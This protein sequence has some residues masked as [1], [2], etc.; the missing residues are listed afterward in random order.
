MPTER[1]NQESQETLERSE[2]CGACRFY[3]PN[4]KIGSDFGTCHRHPPTPAG[5]TASFFP[6]VKRG[7]WCGEFQPDIIDG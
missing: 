7:E 3:E 1:A 2:N 4:L 5:R 6:A